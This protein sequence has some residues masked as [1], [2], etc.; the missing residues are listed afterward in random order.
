[1]TSSR[2][3]RCSCA[4]SPR[5]PP[6]SNI[7]CFWG[8]A[9][10][11]VAVVEPR[12]HRQGVSQPTSPFPF[13]DPPH[14]SL[15]DLPGP[16][17][18][19]GP[20]RANGDGY[21]SSPRD[22]AA[23][24]RP[25]RGELGSRSAPPLPSLGSLVLSGHPC[26][27]LS[28]SCPLP[29]AFQVSVRSTQGPIDVFLCPEDSSGVCSPVKSPFK[30]PAEDS[31]P[32]H[33]QPRAALLLHPAQDVNMPLLPGEQGGAGDTRGLVGC[34]S[35]SHQPL[36]CWHKQRDAAQGPQ[37]GREVGRQDLHS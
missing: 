18:H 10:W 8:G 30:A 1:M 25:S 27:A 13:L 3:A 6:T 33:S 34:H 9:G 21:Q 14:R 37:Q 2:C 19:C 7:L 23:G 36:C 15:C 32:S 24:L 35:G 22:P 29:Q 4:C 11:V 31:S 28:H 17:Q 26:A 20:R 5:T 16:P 12:C